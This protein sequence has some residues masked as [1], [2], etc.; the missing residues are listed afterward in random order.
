MGRRMVA[1]PAA[2]RFEVVE[3]RLRPR[4]TQLPKAARCIIHVHQHG[5]LRATIF[6]PVVQATVHLDELAKHELTSLELP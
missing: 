4:E 5:A 6:E 1:V 3:S 2:D